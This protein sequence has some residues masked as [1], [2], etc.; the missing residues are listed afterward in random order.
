[1]Y[2]RAVRTLAAAGGRVGLTPGPIR[3]GLPEELALAGLR[4]DACSVAVASKSAALISFSSIS[5]VAL[6]AWLFGARTILFLFPVFA[7]A[8]S[9]SA[10]I[11]MMSHPARAGARL[12]K[13]VLSGSM[14]GTNLMIM[15]LR[16]EQSLSSAI[17]FASEGDSAFQKEL[18]RCVWEVVMAKHSGFEEAVQR[19]GDRFA[20]HSSEFKSS[21]DALVTASCEATPE[22]L[23]RAL[24]RANN[25]MVAGAKRRIEEYALS[26][27]TPSMVMFGL[28]ILLPLMVGSF[29]PMLSWDLWSGGDGTGGARVPGE[30]AVTPETV[31]IMNFLFPAVALLVAI[32]TASRHPLVRAPN[33]SGAGVQL[34]GLAGVIASTAAGVLLSTHFLEGVFEAL[35]LLW[36]SVGPASVWLATKSAGY[37]R[38]PSAEHALEGA[39][40]R[41]GARMAEGKN[42]EK[43][44]A[45]SATEAKGEAGP[46]LRELSLAALMPSGDP[47]PDGART[48]S[49]MGRSNSLDALDVVWRAS[50]KDEQAAGMLAMDLAA[51]LKDLNDLALT[52]RIRLK[53]IISMMKMTAYALAPLVLGV[54]FAMYV[55]LSSIAGSVAD[56]DAAGPF[57]VVLGLFLAETNAVVMYFVWGIDGG[58]DRRQLMSSIGQSVLCS[59]IVYSATAL[60]VAL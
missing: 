47:S 13:E 14:S 60:A 22:G 27:S 6:L 4:V 18:R 55:S 38:A 17:M 53:P 12:M 34:P 51:Y 56:T 11:L 5:C 26:L 46:L 40:F 7:T 15:S 31:L 20:R 44:F 1:M 9:V 42:F 2:A 37:S 28:G 3:K 52:L 39:L 21:M 36:S 58:S 16:Q 57:L 59:E 25:A 32:G 45:E 24:D 23:R 41:T 49:R 30:I 10:H 8:A 54:T 50:A 33:R 29:L 19:M 48:A 43:A 35:G